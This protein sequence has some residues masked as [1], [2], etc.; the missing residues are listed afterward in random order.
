MLVNHFSIFFWVFMGLLYGDMVQWKITRKPRGNH[1][2][3]QPHL[4][5]FLSSRCDFPRWNLYSGWS[6]HHFHRKKTQCWWNPLLSDICRTK[7]FF[8]HIL[9]LKKSTTKPNLISMDQLVRKK[10]HRRSA[11]CP[12]HYGHPLM[13]R[14]RSWEDT[15]QQIAGAAKPAACGRARA[16]D[17]VRATKPGIFHQAWDVNWGRDC[18]E[19]V[20]S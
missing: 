3:Y 5:A 18:G 9:P 19:N 13:P 17:A 6:N 20:D 16:G 1:S 10:I 4:R 14:F 7:L 2:L 12:F 8:T 11:F 15:L